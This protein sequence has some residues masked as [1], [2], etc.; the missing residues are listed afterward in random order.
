MAVPNEKI[1][2]LMA[3]SYKS[4]EKRQVVTVYVNMGTT[5]QSRQLVFNQGERGWTLRSLTPY[6]TSDAPG[7][8]LRAMAA[9]GADG[10][11]EIPARSVVT[12]VARFA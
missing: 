7:D 9:M 4:D 11:I 12:L 10:R 5:P 8:E 3:S 1:D 2:G 6:I